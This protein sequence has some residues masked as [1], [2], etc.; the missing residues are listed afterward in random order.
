MRKE[1][2]SKLCKLESDAHVLR[3]IREI[4]K[5]LLS[6]GAY[7]TIG[8]EKQNANFNRLNVPQ[9]ERAIISDA[10]DVQTKLSHKLLKELHI[11]IKDIKME[12]DNERN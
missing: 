4:K 1:T 7:S 2:L 11:L 5:I 9:W 3:R 8:I 10:W 12:L 6:T